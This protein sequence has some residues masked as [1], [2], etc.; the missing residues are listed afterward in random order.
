MWIR[1]FCVILSQKSF[2]FWTDTLNCVINR[3][4]AGCRSLNLMVTPFIALVS[5]VINNDN[6]LYQ[7]FTKNKV[8]ENIVLFIYF[9][10]E[11]DSC[12]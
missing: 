1:D 9:R 10:R 3:V 2:N 5:N 7:K 4:M 11:N 8:L 12:M 6:T